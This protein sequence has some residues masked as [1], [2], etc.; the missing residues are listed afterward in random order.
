MTHNGSITRSVPSAGSGWW[1]ARDG[2]GSGAPTSGT[3]RRSRASTAW[4]RI[5]YKL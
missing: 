2:V 3:S 1:T 5:Y 4:S